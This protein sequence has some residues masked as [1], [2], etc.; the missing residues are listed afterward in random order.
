MNPRDHK[1]K[2]ITGVRLRQ[3]GIFFPI[4]FS[5]APFRPISDY[6]DS[7]KITQIL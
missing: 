6:T 1:N 2:F 3:F 5:W 7:K 4:Q